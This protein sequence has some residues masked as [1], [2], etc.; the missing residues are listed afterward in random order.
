MKLSLNIPGFGSIENNPVSKFPADDNFQI[1]SVINALGE[2]AIYVGGFLMFFWAVWGVF[3]Y[4]R[5]EGNKENLAKARKKIQWAIAGFVIL[6]AAFFVS[7]TLQGILLDTPNP[8]W[9]K[10]FQTITPPE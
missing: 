9:N 3:D 5:A 7:D 2:I 6:L 4:L 8:N 1:A 10:N